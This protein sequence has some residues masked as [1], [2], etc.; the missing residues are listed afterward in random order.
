MTLAPISVEE[1][2]ISQI[3][4]KMTNR[5]VKCFNES[6]EVFNLNISAL[7]SDGRLISQIRTVNKGQ[8]LIQQCV[9][10]LED[11]KCN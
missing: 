5:L 1:H 4:P 8:Q 9:D 2:V 10:A 3:K 11:V 7:I 6:N